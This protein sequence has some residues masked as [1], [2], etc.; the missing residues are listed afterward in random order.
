MDKRKFILD[1]K[2]LKPVDLM[3]WA[4]WFA[5]ADRHVAREEVN[6][7]LVSTVFLGTDHNF[8]SGGPP[9]LFETMVFP[10]DSAFAS[11]DWCERSSTW[12]DAE[13]AHKRGC[14]FARSL[15]TN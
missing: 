5:T 10:A 14:D 6:G 12:D 4:R 2:D 7:H 9:L 1:G 8:G 15:A 11:Q 13:Q 3:T